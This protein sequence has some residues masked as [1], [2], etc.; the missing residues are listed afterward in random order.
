MSRAGRGKVWVRQ[1]Q[2]SWCRPGFVGSY[3]YWVQARSGCHMIG[4]WIQETRCWG[5]EETLIGEPADRE[6]GRLVPQNNHLTRVWIIFY[7]SEIKK[8][9][10][11]KVK[12]QNREMQW[13]SKVKGSS[14]LQN[15]SKG[16]A[17]LYKRYVNLFYSWADRDKLSLH[18]LSKGT[19]VYRQ[20]E[21]Q[22]PPGKPLSVI[23]IIKPN[24][25]NSFQH[26]ARI[27]FLPAITFQ[28]QNGCSLASSLQCTTKNQRP[29]PVCEA[30]YCRLYV[31]CTLSYSFMNSEL[32]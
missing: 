12:R 3:C 11:T 9:W 10:G 32:N 20:A 24:Q 25:R 2:S 14:A 8:Q 7:W 26:G 6:D 19:L 27:G 16:M 21:G 4:Q 15:I 31:H 1:T 23:I 17:S 13:G 30:L 5:K 28:R 22:C 29:Y 18:E